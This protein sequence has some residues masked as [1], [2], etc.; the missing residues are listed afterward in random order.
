MQTTVTPTREQILAFCAEAP[1]ERVFLEDVAR[2]GLGRFT[3]VED[4]R[5]WPH[6]AVQRGRERRP[7][8]PRLRR[9]RRGRRR[10]RRA[11]AHRRGGR[12]RR[13]V[14][15]GPRSAPAATRRPAGPDR[16]TSSAPRPSRGRPR[17]GRRVRA[18][19]TASYRRA[20]R[21]TKKR[22]GSI[23]CVVIR[24]ASGGGRGS[25][26][27]RVARGSGSRTG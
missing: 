16:S 23:R 26:S 22:S 15:R 12:G 3:A 5:G 20:R 19:S 27:R 4:G 6:G 8:G 14:G 17:C 21:P 9:V 18:I 24:T 10:W 11:N 1:V 2:R 13:A 7:V 25:R